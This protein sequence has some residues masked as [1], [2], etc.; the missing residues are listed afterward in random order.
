MIFRDLGYRMKIW[1]GECRRLFGRVRVE[2]FF[3]LRTRE[4][5]DL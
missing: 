4:E 2:E 5:F 1:D 3:F